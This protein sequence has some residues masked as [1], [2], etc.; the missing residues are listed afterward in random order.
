MQHRID[1]EHLRIL[2][3]VRLTM[4]DRALFRDIAQHRDRLLRERRCSELLA[5]LT[6]GWEVYGIE[7]VVDD[8]RA[9]H[10]VP[11]TTGLGGTD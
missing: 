1:L 4:A 5:F 9:R 8:T 2:L 6:Q 3:G 7:S 10:S 11:P